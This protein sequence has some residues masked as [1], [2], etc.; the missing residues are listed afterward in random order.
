VPTPLS[1]TLFSYT[2]LFRAQDLKEQ[3]PEYEFVPVYWMAT[4]DHDFQEINHTKV[5]GKTIS[6]QVPDT[7]ATGR[8]STETITETVKEYCNTFGLSENAS[9]LTELVHR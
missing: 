3:F 6:W 7:A 4:E 1:F 8:I 9:Q 2:T 5:F